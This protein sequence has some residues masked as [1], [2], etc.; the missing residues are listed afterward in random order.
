MNLECRTR[1]GERRQNFKRHVIWKTERRTPQPIFVAVWM[2]G[3]RLLTFWPD[4]S[5]MDGIVR[6]ALVVMPEHIPAF[7][8]VLGFYVNVSPR[9]SVEYDRVGGH[10]AERGAFQYGC[11]WFHLK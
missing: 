7:G 3:H 9:R 8:K 10:V 4:A 1:S 5:D 11:G 2:G 6:E